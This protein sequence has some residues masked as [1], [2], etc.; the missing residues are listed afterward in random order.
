MART[1]LSRGDFA[2]GAT[3]LP[4]AGSGEAAHAA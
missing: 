2:V 1:A 4:D 3:A